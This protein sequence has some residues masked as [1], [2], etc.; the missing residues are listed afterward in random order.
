MKL[1]RISVK[2]FRSLRHIDIQVNKNPLVI[3]GE[4]NVGKS[5]FLLA[6]RLLLGTD[7][8]RLRAELSEEDINRTAM[9][10]GESFFHVILEIGDLQK[11][12]D[13]EVCFKERIDTN[14]EEHFITIKGQYQQNPEG[15]YEWETLL[16]PPSGR[17]NGPLKLSN[18][19]YEAIPLFFLDAVRDGDRETRATGTGMLSQLLRDVKYDDVAGDVLDRLKQANDALNGSAQIRDLSTN[20]TQQLTGLVPGGQGELIIVV[21]DE[22]MSLLSR[23]LR[24]RIRKRPEEA[25]AS[26]SMQGTGL[27]NLTLISIFQH[28]IRRKQEE[29]WKKTP[30][31]AIEEPE[32]HLHPHAQR[33]LYKDLSQINAPV[34]VTTH[35]PALVKYADPSSLV[36]LRA[37]SPDEVTSFQLS[38][39]FPTENEKQLSRLVRLD[40]AEVFFARVIIAVEGDSELIALSAFAEQLGCD[41]DR[42]G[43]SILNMGSNSFEP[44]LRAFTHQE[45]ST[46]FAI[47]YDEDVLHHDS[48]LVK[49]AFQLGQV[50]KTD[51]EACRKSYPQAFDDRKNLLNCSI[52]WFGADDCFER[53]TADAGYLNSMVQAIKDNDQQHNSDYKVLEQYLKDNGLTL[54]TD[55]LVRF[56]KDKKRNDLKVPMAHSIAEAVKT[57]E[58]VPHCFASAIRHA[59]LLSL[60]GIQIDEYFE[61]RVCAT[62]FRGLLIQSIKDEG[63]SRKLKEL[64]DG[65]PLLSEEEVLQLFFSKTT[66]GSAIR[67]KTKSMIAD[68][69]EEVG[70]LNFARTIRDSDFAIHEE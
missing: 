35:S 61:M 29:K 23:N 21:A 70:C 50:S 58:A 8:Q 33:R 69:V 44:I 2:N 16:M 6:L 17:S 37:Q 24:L 49:Q 18:R 48:K 5:N 40:G 32:A 43:I 56:I 52:G 3:L 67:H 53:V 39:N 65:Y 9:S 11:H 30:I 25:H 47:I 14:G 34:I 20:L 13:V 42:D 64:A 27:Q 38:P 54:N 68:A 26:L 10:S 63:L 62:G 57:I 46:R 41:L 7:A 60:G 66:E 55:S 28:Q 51:Y 1:R 4:N 31:L 36:I 15:D 12:P 22:D 59:S 19:M 45:L